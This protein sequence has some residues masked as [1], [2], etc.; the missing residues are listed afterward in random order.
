MCV[1]GI[2]IGNV[3]LRLRFASEEGRMCNME[4][5]HGKLP[6]LHI[7]YDLLPEAMN[8][9]HEN[10]LHSILYS[11]LRSAVRGGIYI[12]VKILYIITG[13]LHIHLRWKGLRGEVQH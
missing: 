8:V 1:W 13:M 5:Q 10:I 4:V 7:G 9:Q 11:I 6:M 3:A 2:S 12:W